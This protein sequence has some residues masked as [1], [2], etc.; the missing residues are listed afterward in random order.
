MIDGWCTRRW[1][2]EFATENQVIV[3]TAS[4]MDCCTEMWVNVV[5][6]SDRPFHWAEFFDQEVHPG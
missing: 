4:L 5:R 6:K 1:A 2:L 3:V